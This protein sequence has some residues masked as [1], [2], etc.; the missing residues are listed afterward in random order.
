MKYLPIVSMAVIAI[1]SIIALI[2]NSNRIEELQEANEFKRELI[3][4]YESYY[5]NVEC[6]LDELDDKYNWVD[7]F[8]PQE[9]YLSKEGLNSLYRIEL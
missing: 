2:V 7:S 5:N 9:Y 3:T 4:K 6:L 8:D 1:L